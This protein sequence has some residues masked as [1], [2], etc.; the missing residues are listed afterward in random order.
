ME[1]GQCGRCG[2]PYGPADLAGVGILRPRTAGR[3]GPLLEYACPG[4]GLVMRFIPHGDGRYARPGEPPPA[5]VPPEERAPAW[6]RARRGAPGDEGPGPPEAA[7][8]AAQARGREPRRPPAPPVGE[9]AVGR[10]EEALALLGVGA[11][12]SEEEIRAAFRERSLTCHPDKVAHLDAEIRDAAR[13]K[14]ER[15]REALAL[16]TGG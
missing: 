15:L 4:C 10:L 8:G 2:M 13:R 5:P 16:L 9:A 1:Q 12:A 11:G 7:D 14:F 6:A 3:G